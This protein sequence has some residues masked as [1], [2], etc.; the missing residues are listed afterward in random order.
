MSGL[1]SFLLPIRPAPARTGLV[2]RAF[3]EEVKDFFTDK[4]SFRHIKNLSPG[5]TAQ[6]ILLS[7]HGEDGSLRRK[8]VVKVPINR[9]YDDDLRTERQWLDA[10]RG[11]PHIIAAL[12]IDVSGLRR[13]VLVMEYAARGDLAGL[14]DRLQNEQGGPVIPNRMM[15]RFFL[16]CEY[17]LLPTLA[18]FWKFRT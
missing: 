4:P 6:P 7:E 2:I 18:S 12:N 3:H 5:M 15:W 1:P 9:I 8:L 16:C 10:L 11:S 13:P 14:V 17:C